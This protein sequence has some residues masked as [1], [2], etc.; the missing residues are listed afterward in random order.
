MLVPAKQPSSY[1]W[2][3][4]LFLWRQKRKYGKVLDPAL[5][6][7]RSPWA[8]AALALLY[9]ALDRKRSPLDPALRSLVTVRVS[10]LNHCAFCVDI[11]SATLLMRGVALEK[12]ELLDGWRESGIFSERERTCLEFA[13]A[14][15]R[16]ER[17]ATDALVQR[18]RTY[19]DDDAIVELTALIAF[20]NMSSKFNAALGV[21][22]QG[23]CQLP[24]HTVDAVSEIS[25]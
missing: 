13:E 17:G 7:G 9:G 15:T 25:P 6:W 2:L 18:L 3:V 8:F 16:S 4:R 10:Q 5:L 24:K 12:V 14:M 19:Y 21:P 22:P 23:F 20:Q 11:N 1:P